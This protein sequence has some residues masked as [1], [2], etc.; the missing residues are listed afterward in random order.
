MT[1][2]NDVADT[3][4]KAI[5]RG[6]KERCTKG[7]NSALQHLATATDAMLNINP[8]R[9]ISYLIEAGQ[10]LQTYAPD[11]PFTQMYMQILPEIVENNQI[12][13]A[14]LPSLRI[15]AEALNAL[16]NEND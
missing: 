5:L 4:I 9:W 3:L 10:Y 2:T 12:I 1:K 16:N 13:T 7:N 14:S 8:I 11:K 15:V 6:E